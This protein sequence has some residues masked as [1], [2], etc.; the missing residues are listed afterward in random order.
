MN[1]FAE[2]LVAIQQA[3][4]SILHT[5]NDKKLFASLALAREMQI[6]VN[7]LIEL[8]TDKIEEKRE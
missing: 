6:E 3:Q 5:L 2:I 4:A 7:R 8:I 1:D